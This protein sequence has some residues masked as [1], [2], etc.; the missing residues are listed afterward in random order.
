MILDLNPFNTKNCSFYIIRVRLLTLKFITS[1]FL[2][3]LYYF[4]VQND[5]SEKGNAKEETISNF[6][7]GVRFHHTYT[8]I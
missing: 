4:R 2:Y 7:E 5:P 3:W 1:L 6:T 8:K